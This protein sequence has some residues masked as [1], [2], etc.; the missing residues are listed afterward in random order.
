MNDF[1]T[2]FLLLIVFYVHEVSNTIQEFTFPEEYQFDDT[3][4][5]NYYVIV[6]VKQS[7]NAD[8]IGLSIVG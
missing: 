7:Q 3:C 5:N 2:V 1:K 8:L 6:E 4:C